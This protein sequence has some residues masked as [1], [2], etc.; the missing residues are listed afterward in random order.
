M[1]YGIMKKARIGAFL[2]L[3]AAALIAGPSYAAELAAVQ[4]TAMMP[5]GAMIPMWGFVEVPV[6]ATFDCSTVDPSAPWDRGPTLTAVAAGSLTVNV[7]NCL[8]EPVSVFIPGQYK[9]L[10]PVMFLDSQ[11]RNRVRSF[12]AQTDPGVVG[13]YTWNNLKEGTYIYHSGTHP[14]VQVQMGIYGGLV[15]TGESYPAVADEH[16]LLYSEIDPGLHAAVDGGTY[17]TSAY[18]STFDYYPKYFLIN[19][20]SFP[21]TVPLALNTSEDVLLRFVN[22]G[23]RTHVP[24]L[25]GLYMNVIAEDGFLYQHPKEQY[26]I[27]LAAAKT[28]D[29]IVNAGTSGTYALYDRALHLTNAAA[30]G[31]GM[32]TYLNAGAAAGAPTATDDNYT[33]AEDAV[34]GL[35]VAAPGILGNDTAAGGGSIPASYTASLV[36]GPSAGTLGPGLSADGSFTYTP[37]LDFNGTDI[38]TYRAV[39]TAV[40]PGPDS[41]VA[42]VRITVTPVN[43]PPSAVANAY[44]APAGGTLSVAAPGVL[45]ND[46]DVDGDPLA[47]AP[48]GTPIGLTLNPDG[49]FQYTPTGAAGAIEIFQYVANDGTAD[50]GPATVT[51][52]V[53]AAVNVPPFANPDFASTPRNTPV[54]FSVTANDVDADGTINV[55]TVD[56][57]PGTAGIQTTVTTTRGGTATVDVSGNVTFTPKRGFRG[58]DTFTYTVQD[59][60]GATSNIATV[61]V[62]VL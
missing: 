14:Q 39:D 38:F 35:T 20:K 58:T 6:A 3:L 49:S 2:A 62:N 45:G 57:N 46:T 26:S 44:N 56:L 51:I 31:G 23:L 30:T 43:D 33:M 34:G 12:D 41:N 15:V 32:L 24:T 52:T 61:T 42:T 22:A 36:T 13:S 47:A 9:P 10:A 16:V 17:G 4:A 18:P 53:I 59:N 19:G 27:E 8:T 5:D 50:S 55:A 11:G 40:I 60:A 21:D 25:Q 29:A 37:N 7:K 48:V 54:T 28:M 1:R